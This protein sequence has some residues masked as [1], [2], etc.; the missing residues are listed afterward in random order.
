MESELKCPELSQLKARQ[1][2]QSPDSPRSVGW[3][4]QSTPISAHVQVVPTAEKQR[5]PHFLISRP[6][7][8]L[9]RR[10]LRRQTIRAP[11]FPAFLRVSISLGGNSTGQENDKGRPQL[12]YTFFFC[13]HQFNP[14]HWKKKKEKAAHRQTGRP[15][16]GV[17]GGAEGIYEGENRIA[18]CLSAL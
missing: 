13:L 6:Q 4:R 7:T 5:Y 8:Y 17:G 3:I 9:G 1:Q 11:L 12:S 14:K 2:A 15:G 16:G 10:A 18:P